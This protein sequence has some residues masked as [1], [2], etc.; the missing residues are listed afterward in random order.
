[1]AIDF[2]KIERIRQQTGGGEVDKKGLI[3]KGYIR[4]K[5]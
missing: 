2:E 3:N 5:L 1:M 4:S